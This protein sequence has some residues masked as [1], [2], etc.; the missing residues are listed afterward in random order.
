MLLI[1]NVMVEQLRV[2]YMEKLRMLILI[3]MR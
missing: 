2:K 3:W 1:L